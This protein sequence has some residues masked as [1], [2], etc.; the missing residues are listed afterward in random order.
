MV[1]LREARP[2]EA[3]VS[4]VL[5]W[6]FT[7]VFGGPLFTRRLVPIGVVESDWKEADR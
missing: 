7:G 3:C 5:V 2:P 4:L 1:R 6:D